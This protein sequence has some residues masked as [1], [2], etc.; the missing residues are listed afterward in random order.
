MRPGGEQAGTGGR[1]G[2]T[3]GSTDA[4]ARACTELTPPAAGASAAGHRSPVSAGGKLVAP[5]GG[6]AQAW[7]TSVAAWRFASIPASPSQPPPWAAFAA[8]TPSPRW[9]GRRLAFLQ[10]RHRREHKKVGS[11]LWRDVALAT[12][13][14]GRGSVAGLGPDPRPRT[15]SREAT[16]ATLAFATPKLLTTKHLLCAG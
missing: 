8:K 6:M 11:L 3:S 2:S 1:G 7:F 14:P 5:P 4:R 15:A 13:F 12:G 9:H 10:L 16:P